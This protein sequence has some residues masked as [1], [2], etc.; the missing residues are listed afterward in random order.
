MK[1]GE[2]ATQFATKYNEYFERLTSLGEE[3]AQEMFDAVDP[4]YGNGGVSVSWEPTG[5]GSCVIRASGEDAAFIEFGTGVGVTYN[6]TFSIQSDFPI[7][8]GSWSRERNGMYAQRGYW[9]YTTPDGEKLMLKGTP[10][11]GGMQ[12]AC[13]KM[14]NQSPD[15]ARR[16]FG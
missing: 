10:A 4:A 5:S 13:I 9:F 15:I 11:M 12:E 6:P 7:E 2:W 14:Q 1:F 8:D 16:T 3:T